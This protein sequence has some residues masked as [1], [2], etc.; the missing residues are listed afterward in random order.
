M[1]MVIFLVFDKKQCSR[2]Y[3]CYER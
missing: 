2:L 1:T 3:F